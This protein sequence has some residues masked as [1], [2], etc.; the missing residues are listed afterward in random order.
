MRTECLIPLRNFLGTKIG[1]DIARSCGEMKIYW[2]LGLCLVLFAGLLWG[3]F[4]SQRRDDDY[5]K[6]DT[7]LVTIPVV[8]PIWLPFLPLAYAAITSFTAVSAAKQFWMSENLF[9]ETSDMPKKEFLQYRVGDD[10]AHYSSTVAAAGT[11]F[12]GNTAL[13]GPFLRADNR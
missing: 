13:F 3:H 6:T 8:L 5:D 11:A 12:I 2:T 10:R 4:A 9:F 7:T 1:G